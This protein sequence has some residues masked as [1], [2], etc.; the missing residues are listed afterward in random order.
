ML[1]AHRRGD[2]DNSRQIWT[3]LVFMLWYDIFVTEQVIRASVHPGPPVRSA[4]VD[5]PDALRKPV[6]T[7]LH[8]RPER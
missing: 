3:L 7:R 6:R 5:H 2:A 8:D 4:F 1:D